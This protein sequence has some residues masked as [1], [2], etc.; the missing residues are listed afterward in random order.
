MKEDNNEVQGLIN[1]DREQSSDIELDLIR[2]DAQQDMGQ[3]PLVPCGLGGV[4]PDDH[5][6]VVVDTKR[7]KQDILPWAS[8]IQTGRPNESIERI[9]RRRAAMLTSCPVP[10][11]SEA[12]AIEAPPPVEIEYF[13]W[14]LII[15]HPTKMTIHLDADN[16]GSSEEHMG[17]RTISCYSS[18]YPN[19]V[20]VST[21]VDADEVLDESS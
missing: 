14:P 10:S 6:T 4:L 7:P 5:F 19:S 17:R 20:D 11:D 2:N 9:I 12:K 8:E 13:S 15:P 3:Q 21:G 16:A 18:S 1:D